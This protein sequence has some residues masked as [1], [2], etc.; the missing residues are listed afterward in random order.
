[1]TPGVSKTLTHS[2]Q[3]V[4]V[5]F[6]AGF[7][8]PLVEGYVT[9]SG[10]S[11]GREKAAAAAARYDT[12]PPLQD[13]IAALGG[14]PAEGIP[15]HDSLAL[16]LLEDVAPLELAILKVLNPKGTWRDIQ[17][18]DV[19]LVAYL[20]AW[21]KEIQ[22]QPE[23]VQGLQGI[24]M[25][26]LPAQVQ[27]LEKMFMRF[28][29]PGRLSNEEKE[30][31]IELI[32]AKAVTVVLAKQGAEIIHSLGEPLEVRLAGQCLKPFIL[33]KDLRSGDIFREEWQTICHR[34]GV[35]DLDLGQA[36]R[37]DA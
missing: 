33:V 24:L 28:S 22:Q 11:K 32:I 6:N 5:W 25:G 21:K 35:I 18:R 20:P 31:A 26:D 19:V 7:R 30:F 12:H 8:T 27:D 15:T 2:A 29:L 37:G 3:K 14:M 10:S 16:T 17:W 23:I 13:R 36:C 1:M 4:D 9:F 34:A